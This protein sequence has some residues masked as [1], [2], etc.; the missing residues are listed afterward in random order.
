MRMECLFPGITTD[1][2]FDCVAD[3]RVRKKW[4]HR[5]ERYDVIEKTDDYILQYNKLMKVNIPFFAQRDQLVKQF[6]KKD[7]P[8]TGTH[9]SVAMSV[10]HPNYPDGFEGCCRTHATMIGYLF[11]P[12]P[13]NNGCKVEWVYI[14]DLKG[15]LPG[16]M[17]QMLA[18]KM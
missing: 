13:E 18:N 16:M 14:N 12:Y 7:Y 17:V 3:I 6:L 8:E 5:L 10:E 2:A 9:I 1:V 4:D 15:S 11:T